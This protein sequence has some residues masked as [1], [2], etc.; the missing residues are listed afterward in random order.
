MLLIVLISGAP[1]LTKKLNV[2]KNNHAHRMKSPTGYII[3]KFFI[4]YNRD[5]L[6]VP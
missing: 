2:D 5:C 3:S 4:R 6:A 1:S